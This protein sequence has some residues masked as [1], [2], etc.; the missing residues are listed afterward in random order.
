MVSR[1]EQVDVDDGS[2]DLSVWLPPAG[3]GPGVL[4]IQEIFGVSDYIR[5]VAEDLAADGYVVGAPDLFWRLKHGHD[6][7]HDEA[8]LAESLELVSEFDFTLGVADAA[9]AFTRLAALP[10]VQGGAGVLGFCLGGAIAYFLAP[11][12]DADAVI[13]FYGSG[14]ADSLEV[15]EE[16]TVPI[17]FHFG[18]QDSYIPRDQVARVESAV[19]A[20]DNAEI[21][22]QEDAGHA[23]HNHRAPMFHVP[24][25]AER[26]WHRA[27]EFLSRHLPTP[28]H[29]TPPS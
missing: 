2:F 10:E 26:A 27:K 12:V 15:L 24:A 13:S 14:V 25:A 23:F 19:A 5:D 6:A 4:L 1:V 3:Q 17:Q 22:V 20:R 7:V 16:I 29:P 11:Q 8:G 21:H 28:H 18:G 9:A